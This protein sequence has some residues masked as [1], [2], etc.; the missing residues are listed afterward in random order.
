MKIGLV[1]DTHDEVPAS[2]HDALEGV[3][4][5]LHAG[6]VC[7]PEVLAEIE[8]IAPVTAVHGNMDRRPLADEIPPELLLDREGIRIALVHGH[9]LRQGRI[10]D[11]LIEKY[12]VIRPDVVVFGHTHEP[13]S[14]KWEGT[15]YVNPGTAGGVGNDPTCAI[16]E[17]VDD[18]YEVEHVELGG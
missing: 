18:W 4:E 12:R 16:L 13:V 5:I 11:D 10:L 14:R 1:S 2:L 9:R 17:V 8:T 15:H 3:D 7:G 6:D